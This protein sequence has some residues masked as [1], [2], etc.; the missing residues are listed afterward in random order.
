MLRLTV[1]IPIVD[2]VPGEAMKSHLELLVQ[3]ARTAKIHVSTPMNLMPHD[4]ARS[5][6]MEEA[7]VSQSDYLLFIDDDMIVPKEAYCL[8]LETMTFKKPKPVAVSGHYYR[9]G[10]PYT[11]VWSKE[12]EKQFHCVD[13]TAGT[14]EIHTSGLGCCLIDVKWVRENLTAPYFSMKPGEKMTQVT[15]D[16]T[17][18]DSIRAAGGLVLGNAEVRCGHLGER[19][20]IC[21]QTVVNL[22]ATNL[23]MSLT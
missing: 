21:D 19:V 13:A 2:S 7:F 5:I 12:V 15:D 1:G 17:F 22:R 16:I 14:H 23:Q 6:V 8:L 9:R 18:F 3:I 11:C 10:Y 20:V 4:R